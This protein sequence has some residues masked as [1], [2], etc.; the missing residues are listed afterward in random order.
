[1]NYLIV[2]TMCIIALAIG[3][4]SLIENEMFETDRKQY[5]LVLA[6]IIMVEI[7]LDSLGFYIEASKIEWS[8][9]YRYVKTLEFL[10]APLV[11]FLLAQVIGRNGY[12]KKIAKLFYIM[13]IINTIMQFA[14]CV[15]PI[16]FYISPD[17][18]YHRASLGWLYV[19]NIAIG[20]ILLILSSKNAC[21][22]NTTVSYTLI[23]ASIFVLVGMIIRL[24]MPKC[25][26]DWLAISFDYII[27]IL[28]YNNGYLKVD[29]TTMLLNRRC[30]DNRFNSINYRTALV[31]IDAN[32]FKQINDRFGHD[33]GDL[34][35][36]L[37]AEAIMNVYSQDGWC[38]RLGGDEFAVIF[39]PKVI[40][41]K[42][43]YQNK[44][45]LCQKLMNKLDKEISKIS[46]TNLDEDGNEILKYGVSQGYVIRY[47][48]TPITDK[49]KEKLFRIADQKMY[50]RKKQARK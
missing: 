41:P 20:I 31:I 49:E 38:Y 39:K 36:A 45:G 4:V 25:N 27:I 6:P 13:I 28:V 24:Y 5:M 43:K 33:T 1:M 12:R 22:Q 48:N 23:G 11:P 42:T 16:I 19:G 17:A 32:C 34:A 29:S 30:F 47:R 7:I 15:R 44:Y 26:A 18:V 9:L 10:I 8:D 14:N 3:Y 21:I 35:L 37:I 46:K 40:K 2:G 50:E